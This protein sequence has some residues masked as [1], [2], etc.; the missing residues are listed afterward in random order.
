MRPQSLGHHTTELQRTRR[1]TENRE[2]R[3]LTEQRTTELRESSDGQEQGSEDT[4]ED[5][6]CVPKF[7]YC[8]HTSRQD[9]TSKW[10]QPAGKDFCLC[11]LQEARKSEKSGPVKGNPPR[12]IHSSPHSSQKS[13]GKLPYSR[14]HLE[15]APLL[16]GETAGTLCQRSKV[17]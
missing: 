15:V 17:S 13:L 11:W 8:P 5:T 9:A 14:S 4:G 6:V 12:N 7:T 3:E 1:T 10:E 16:P 2:L